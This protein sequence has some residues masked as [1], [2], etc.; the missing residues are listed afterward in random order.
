MKKII[1]LFLVVCLCIVCILPAMAANPQIASETNQSNST[2]EFGMIAV[3]N[4]SSNGN[5]IAPMKS[6]WSDAG[7]VS[8]L[9]YLTSGKYIAWSIKPS[10]VVPYYFTGTIYIVNGRGNTAG[11]FPVS[12][13]G[14]GLKDGIVDISHIG[15]TK[16]FH[17]TAVFEGIAK[18]EFINYYVSPNARLPFAY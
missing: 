14:E 11:T 16:G 10:T 18:T 9:D 7:G 6:T 13:L 3:P 5:V 8:T 15:L 1:S 17:Y 2:H 4:D 12:G